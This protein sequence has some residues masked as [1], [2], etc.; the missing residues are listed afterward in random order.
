MSII[1]QQMTAIHLRTARCYLTCPYF[2]DL[3]LSNANLP[4]FPLGAGIPPC[5]VYQIGRERERDRERETERDI[6]E[7]RSVNIESKVANNL[8]EEESGSF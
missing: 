8:R 2:A 4:S 1:L 5:T 7:D 6:P 3:T